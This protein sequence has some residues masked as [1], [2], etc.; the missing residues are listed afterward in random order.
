MRRARGALRRLSIMILRSVFL[1]VLVAAAGCARKALEP[2][3]AAATRV[4]GVP[5]STTVV[6]LEEIPTG[7]E[8][9]GT[10]QA[11]Q[12][13]Q[14]G[15]R[16][17]GTIDEMPVIL[18]QRVGAGDMLVKIAARDVAARALQARTQ[19]EAA[20]RE[21]ERERGLAATGASAKENVRSF[22]DRVATAEA[23]LREA[24]AM[25]DDATIR[26]PFDGVV[27]RKPANVGD[28]AAPGMTLLE[29]HGLDRFE[30]EAAVPETA[31]VGLRVGD[32]V[33]ASVPATA[34]S[35]VGKIAELSSA[36]DVRARA[37]TIKIAVPDTARVH[38]GE[39]VRLRLAGAP[40]SAILVP[41]SAV[42][43]LGQM[44]RVFAVGPEGRAILRLVR[45]GGDQRGRLEILAGIGPGDR[46]IIKP[47]EH[48]R[49]GDLV[50][51]MR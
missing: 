20:R 18:G 17:M 6:R 4:S 41:R 43:V 29:L 25:V 47:P 51:E 28:L 11:V 49:E 26:A 23:R 21:W 33:E 45:T 16:L 13:A 15:A 5:V 50:Q 32:S 31:A 48:L 24:E 36:A 7:T 3:D 19:L 27:A 1:L 44:E 12:R 42:T 46:I 2:A 10:I 14:L 35:F 8:I 34:V 39:F 40:R 9:T 22:E 30:I 37:I 38:S